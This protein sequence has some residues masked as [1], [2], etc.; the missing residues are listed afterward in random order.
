M[1]R[2]DLKSALKSIFF[3]DRVLLDRKL[4]EHRDFTVAMSLLCGLTASG[5]WLW[6]HV[7]DPLG[8]RTTL[9]LRA[10]YLVLFTG[11]ALLAWRGRR[12]WLA[13]LGLAL[14]LG[15]EAVFLAILG[16]LHTGMV[17]G[18]GGFMYY[19]ILPLVL[20]QGLSLRLNLLYTVL[21]AALPQ[22][23]AGAG[24]VQ[25]FHQSHYIV[26]IWPAA[27][28]TAAAQ[29][30]FARSYLKRYT[31]E[32]RLE[33]ASNTDSL[34]G[35]SNRRHFL[36]LLTQEMGRCRRFR[37]P[38]SLLMLDID[39]FKRVNDAFGHPTGDVV[40]QR[41]AEA[42]R[43]HSRDSDVVARLGG[44]EFAVL[45]PEAGLQGALV[46]A[47]RIREDVEGLVLQGPG[48]AEVR[49]T[50]S[51]GAAEFGPFDV[52]EDDLLRRADA[53]LYQAKDAGR[54]RVCS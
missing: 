45:L 48:R 27:F 30:A 53:A 47:E 52:T 32:L 49:C 4:D 6:D 20:F 54:N 34:T 5:L 37:H 13:A 46:Y 2:H 33:L 39:R 21:A 35:V 36:P 10:S 42:C 7:V 18:L 1:S 9:G 51:I 44:E 25:G 31:S 43:A 24:L 23:L 29:T 8:A 22:V 38:L 50:V 3:P 11:F 41:V 26:L 19:F 16:R 40:I 28:V 14:V 15:G 12:Q 17:Y